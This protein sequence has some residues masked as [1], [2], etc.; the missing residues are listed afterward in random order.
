MNRL[1][2]LSRLVASAKKYRVRLTLGVVCITLSNLAA[3]V[4][5]MVLKHAIDSLSTLISE[6]RFSTLAAWSCCLPFW[7]GFFSSS[8]AA[9]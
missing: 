1:S 5:P 2:K 7:R 8:C 4:S 3:T 6:E 9:S